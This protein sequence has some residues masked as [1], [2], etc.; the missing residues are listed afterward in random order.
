M[1]STCPSVCPSVRPSV[2][3]QACEHDILR[4]NQPISMQIGASRLRGKDIKQSTL[5]VKR[6]KFKVDAEVRFRG[7]AEASFLTPLTSIFSSFSRSEIYAKLSSTLHCHPILSTVY[8][9]RS[10]VRDGGVV[11]ETNERKA[12]LLGKSY[13]SMIDGM[14]TAAS[15]SRTVLRKTTHSVV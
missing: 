5:G 12:I 6:L 9:P 14:C 13:A 3:Y 1:F 2:C 8:S 10:G 4:T 11:R 7:L 15:L